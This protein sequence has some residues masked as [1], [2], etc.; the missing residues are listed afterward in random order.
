MSSITPLNVTF[1]HRYLFRP[2]LDRCVAVV[3]AHTPHP[4][5]SIALYI[6]RVALFICCVSVAV[7]ALIF[8][9]VAAL[10]LASCNESTWPKR[11]FRDRTQPHLA[12]FSRCPLKVQS[13]SGRRNNFTF[14]FEKNSRT[15]C[16]DVYFSRNVQKSTISTSKDDFLKV[17]PK[18]TTPSW[19]LFRGG[20]SRVD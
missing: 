18:R 14:S 17:N 6:C 11:M 3:L 2:E 12:C 20:F 19:L 7:L 13:S 8:D 1:D 15:T 16:L 5:A 10:A 9:S 4:S